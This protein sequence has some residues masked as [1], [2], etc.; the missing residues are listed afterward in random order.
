M[1]KLPEGLLLQSRAYKP[2][3]LARIKMPRPQMAALWEVIDTIGRAIMPAEWDGTETL[4]RHFP[5]QAIGPQERMRFS[6]PPKSIAGSDYAPPP[7][8]TEFSFEVF[9]STGLRVCESEQEAMELWEIEK[10]L[11]EAKIA[12]ERAAYLRYLAARSAA[13]E[14]F[15]R[16]EI[17]TFLLEPNTGLKLHVIQDYWDSDPSGKCLDDPANLA[18]IYAR[19][20]EGSIPS[21][22]KGRV[23]V[24][25]DHLAPAEVADSFPPS[26]APT[27]SGGRGR[28]A[29]S[30]YDWERLIA[31]L[32]EHADLNGFANDTFADVVRWAEAW[33]DQNF[34]TP[35]GSTTVRE[36]VERYV[37]HIERAATRP[38]KS[39]KTEDSGNSGGAGGR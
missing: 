5:G 4:A 27:K 13:R 19:A 31:A 3:T 15:A 28:G 16:G 10:P 30:G 14:R 33:C 12:A 25:R 23:F 9:T 39:R 11:V 21:A 38:R 32:I 6:L 35:P 7:L 34:M 29:P 1:P 37:K 22:I 26:A 20:T 24:W 2:P 17:A 18:T 8:D 36:R